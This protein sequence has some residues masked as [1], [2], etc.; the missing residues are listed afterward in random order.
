MGDY[1]KPWRRTI[2]VLTLLM[3]CVFAG[4][5]V[6]SLIVCDEYATH[7]YGCGSRDILRLHAGVIRYLIHDGTLREERTLFHCGYVFPTIPLA[8]LSA[9]LLLSKPRK[10]ARETAGA[11]SIPPLAEPAQGW[12]SC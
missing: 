5:W 7:D 8:M 9:W 4:A 10:P 11:T 12:P 1:F 2:G 6:R 3:A